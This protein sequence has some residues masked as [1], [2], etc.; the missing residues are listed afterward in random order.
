M[1]ILL[2]GFHLDQHAEDVR[3]WL[4]MSSSS[5]RTSAG[6]RPTAR[7]PSARPISTTPPSALAKAQRVCST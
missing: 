7:P 2:D 4:G 5:L 3:A 1:P 6:A